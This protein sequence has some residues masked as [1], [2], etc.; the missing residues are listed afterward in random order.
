MEKKKVPYIKP[1]LK[2]VPVDSLEYDE[3]MRTLHSEQKKQEGASPNALPAA[4]SESDNR[5]KRSDG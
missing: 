3:Y 5:K 1:Q 2:V 4:T